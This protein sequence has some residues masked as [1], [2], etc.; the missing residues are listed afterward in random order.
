MGRQRVGR[1]RVGGCIRVS[2]DWEVMDEFATMR[3]AELIRDR[4][5]RIAAE[6]AISAHRGNAGCVELE[7]MWSGVS[8]HVDELQDG[9]S[10]CLP[11]PRRRW[12]RRR[13]GSR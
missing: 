1:R 11:R 9:S 5:A 13:R 10:C 3:F 7:A 8:G 12:H 4:V 6:R 2:I